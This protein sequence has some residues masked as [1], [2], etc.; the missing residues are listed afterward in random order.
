[1]IYYF[2]INKM[3]VT[4]IVKVTECS[5]QTVSHHI[6]NIR[7]LIQSHLETTKQKIGGKDII[8]EC[9][10]SKFGRVKY[11]RGR[12]REGTWV[13]GAVERTSNKRIFVTVVPDR[14]E[15]TL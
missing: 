4:S 11:H 10:E 9:D 2:W 1:M 5:T 6:N 12:F 7:N 3:F 15:K 8:V 13:F 14:K